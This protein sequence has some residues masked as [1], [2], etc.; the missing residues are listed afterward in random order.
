MDHPCHSMV[1]PFT[2]QPRTQPDLPTLSARRIRIRTAS[3]RLAVDG[4][5]HLQGQGAVFAWLNCGQLLL[6]VG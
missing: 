4:T 5:R 1:P 6:L 2:Q 3:T